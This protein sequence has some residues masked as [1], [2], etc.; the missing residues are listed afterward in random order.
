LWRKVGC[1]GSMQ[2]GSV[3]RTGFAPFRFFN[4]WSMRP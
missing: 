4:H 2:H 1:W 3:V